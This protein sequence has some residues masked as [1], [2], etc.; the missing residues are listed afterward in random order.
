MYT[1][2]C[3]YIYMYTYTYKYVHTDI[4]IV[5]RKKI[6]CI[7]SRVYTC[8]CVYVKLLI[9]LHLGNIF[10]MLICLFFKLLYMKMFV[11]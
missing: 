5:S 2:V 10:C 7:Y 8:I 6:L 11:I 9:V 4:Y 1:Y 3:M